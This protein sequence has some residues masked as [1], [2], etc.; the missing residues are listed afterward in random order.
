VVIEI[1]G[2]GALDDLELEICFWKKMKL[3][4]VETVETVD[5]DF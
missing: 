1:A 4:T 2:C 3:E 5:V